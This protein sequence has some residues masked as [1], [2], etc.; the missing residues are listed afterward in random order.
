MKHLSHRSCL[1][2]NFLDKCIDMDSDT[3]SSI[4]KL[5]KM[6]KKKNFSLKIVRIENFYFRQIDPFWNYFQKIN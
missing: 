6:K 4:K 1:D 5:L 3:Y 2:K